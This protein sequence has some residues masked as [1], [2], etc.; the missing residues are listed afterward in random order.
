MYTYTNPE[1]PTYAYMCVF[2]CEYYCICLAEN[3]K[4]AQKVNKKHMKFNFRSQLKKWT[5]TYEVL[6]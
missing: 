2:L 4:Q 5:E 3:S 6:L 1:T